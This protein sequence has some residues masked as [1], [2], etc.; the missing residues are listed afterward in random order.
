VIALVNS[1]EVANWFCSP[2]VGFASSTAHSEKARRA[3]RLQAQVQ[4]K[5]LAL[6]GTNDD[7]VAPQ[8]GH[9]G[10]S[11]DMYVTMGCVAHSQQ[12]LRPCTA[13]FAVMTKPAGT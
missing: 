3:T 4:S 8:A 13:D 7:E 2:A 1:V 5:L 6:Y 12:M 9:E 11:T 10:R